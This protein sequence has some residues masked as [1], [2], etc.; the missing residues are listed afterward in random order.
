MDATFRYFKNAW[1]EI[2]DYSK[3]FFKNVTE[4]NPSGKLKKVNEILEHENNL[5]RSTESQC[6]IIKLKVL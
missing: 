1:L 3:L 2:F 5:P 6:Y 4:K